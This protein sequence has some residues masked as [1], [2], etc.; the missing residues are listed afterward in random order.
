M[1]G[2][3]FTP[4]VL[5]QPLHP[6][7]SR[8][9]NKRRWMVCV[10]LTTLARILY[11]I[12]TIRYSCNFSNWNKLFLRGIYTKSWSGLAR[13]LDD[14]I[15]LL[16]PVWFFISWYGY[17]YHLTLCTGQ[18][19]TITV[20]RTVLGCVLLWCWLST[21]APVTVSLIEWYFHHD[22][23]DYS[24][25]CYGF[26]W[27]FFLLLKLHFRLSQT[28]LF[29]FCKCTALCMFPPLYILFEYWNENVTSGLL[30]VMF[31]FPTRIFY[32]GFPGFGT[33]CPSGVWCI[34]LTICLLYVGPLLKI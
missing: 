22:F 2:D 29:S 4:M 30:Y 5:A 6:I 24:Y 17:R 15:L 34:G 12:H 19:H 10:L 25:D 3:L 26:L 20:Y 33:N 32:S 8:S 9:R 16:F 27:P 18:R 7:K 31:T 21:G 14:L 28:K 23:H 1:M 11:Y 13:V